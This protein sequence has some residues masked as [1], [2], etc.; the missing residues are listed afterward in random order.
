MYG[1]WKKKMKCFKEK[2]LD[3]MYKFMILFCDFYDSNIVYL[4]YS[5]FEFLVRK[6][7][8]CFDS[9]DFEDI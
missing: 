4:L 2:V 7:N 5:G 6:V 9:V 3:L 1:G 8:G